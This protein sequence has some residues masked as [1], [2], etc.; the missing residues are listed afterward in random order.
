MMR[1][2]MAAIL[3]LCLALLFVCGA[4][5]EEGLGLFGKLAGYEGADPRLKTMAGVAG[6]VGCMFV[7]DEGV[8]VV[9]DQAYYEGDRVYV[10]YRLTGD[11]TQVELHEG[12][13]EKTD[14]GTVYEGEI[15]AEKWSNDDPELQKAVE[16][17]DGK[18]RRWTYS[19]H[20]AV[21]DCMAL[22][23]ES[24]L[25]IVAGE[26]KYR[27]DG[28]VIGWKECLIPYEQCEDTVTFNLVVSCNR[29]TLFQDGNT[30]KR[31]YERGEKIYIPF[32]LDRNDSFQYLY[33]SAEAED[34]E[35]SADLSVGRVDMKGVLCLD[36]E[37]QAKGWAV[38]DPGTDLIL[39]WNLYQDGRRICAAG[40]QEVFAAGTGKIIF[41]LRYPLAEGVDGLTLVPE[42]E[43]SGEHPEEAV[44]VGPNAEE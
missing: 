11:V 6:P 29:E 21:T 28:S 18:G 1:K 7:T 2:T 38:R 35:I 19:V 37:E 23:D 16:W 32:S 12:A 42:Y 40:E 22:D 3:T 36:S 20:T 31:K 17:L 25:S 33:G 26:E 15:A 24:W 10:S 14:W 34:R 44:A 41:E 30:L 27:A 13:P 5:A 39:G 43:K 4:G 9:I 8:N